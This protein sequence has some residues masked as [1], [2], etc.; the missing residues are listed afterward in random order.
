[1]ALVDREPETLDI[2]C[3]DADVTAMGVDGQP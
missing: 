2:N 3:R 1:V